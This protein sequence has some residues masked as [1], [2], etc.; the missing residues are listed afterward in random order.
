[1]NKTKTLLKYVVIAVLVFSVVFS[2]TS[3]FAAV[4]A[5]GAGGSNGDE[6][7]SAPAGGLSNGSE[8]NGTPVGGGSNVGEGNGTPVGGGS[9]ADEGGLTGGGGTTP[10]DTGG[11]HSGGSSRVSGGGTV[12]EISNIRVMPAGSTVATNTL[13]IGKT[14]AITWETSRDSATDTT[15]VLVSNFFGSNIFVGTGANIKGI[16]ELD[17]IVPASAALGNYTLNFSYPKTNADST[18][19]IIATTSLRI[20]QTIART[21]SNAPANV[22]VSPLPQ[23]VEAPVDTFVDTSTTPALTD[24]TQTAAVSNAFGDFLNN[25]YIL[26]FFILLL[27][28]TGL[29]MIQERRTPSG[30]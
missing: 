6:G 22:S 2:A 16:N 19:R 26:W 27:I 28:I 18:Y 4:G 25:K 14:Y 24:Q 15:L 8:G 5:P 9:N 3:A 1:M 13:T 20:P 30:F 10:T 23:I 11:R 29:L 17:W 21:V 7:N 12:L